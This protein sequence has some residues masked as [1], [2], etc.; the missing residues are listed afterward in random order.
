ME[1]H[2][3]PPNKSRDVNGSKYFVHVSHC[4][5]SGSLDMVSVSIEKKRGVYDT[6]WIGSEAIDLNEER[7]WI[8]SGDIYQDT[9]RECLERLLKRVQMSQKDKEKLFGEFFGTYSV[10]IPT[11]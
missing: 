11:S 1:K 10:I 7:F 5:M 4:V 9:A 8:N 3:S 6:Y 2:I